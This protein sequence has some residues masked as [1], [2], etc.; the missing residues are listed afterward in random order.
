MQDAAAEVERAINRKTG[1]ATGITRLETELSAVLNSLRTALDASESAGGRTAPA[2]GA[3]EE[4]TRE[5]MKRLEAYLADSDGEAADY[6]VTQAD[7]LRAALG[8]ERFTGIRKAVEGYD[9]ENAL[10][11]LRA[12]AGAGQATKGARS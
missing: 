7:V 8:A 6:L 12:A 5:A 2:A 9:F 11:K 4:S 10:E 1:T 3:S